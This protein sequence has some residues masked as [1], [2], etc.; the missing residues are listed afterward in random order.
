MLSL[1]KFPF[2][3]AIALQNYADFCRLNIL[4]QNFIIKPMAIYRN[5]NSMKKQE[6][7]CIICKSRG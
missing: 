5:F 4:P 1:Y 2:W 3:R 6:G 7:I